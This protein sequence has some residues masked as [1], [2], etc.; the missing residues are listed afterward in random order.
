MKSDNNKA[1][2]EAYKV[3]NCSEQFL[4]KMS[5]RTTLLLDN[6]VNVKLLLLYYV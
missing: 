6:R 4:I 5:Y 2:V 3:G 1:K